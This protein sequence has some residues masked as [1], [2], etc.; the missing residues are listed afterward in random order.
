[1][2]TGGGDGGEVG[3]SFVRA[4]ISSTC[5]T[6]LS[7]LVRNPREHYLASNSQQGK[8]ENSPRLLK[9]LPKPARTTRNREE[10]KVEARI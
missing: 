2:A 4:W 3:D 7:M 1:M 8:K 6:S 5:T 10:A 9:R